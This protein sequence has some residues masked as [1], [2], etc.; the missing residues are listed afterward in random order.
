V[1]VLCLLFFTVAGVPYA[2]PR[3]GRVIDSATK[4][5]VSGV[6]VVA[7]FWRVGSQDTVW[8]CVRDTTDSSGA[9][10]LDVNEGSGAI[11]SYL[12]AGYGSL[13]LRYPKELNSKNEDYC[14]AEL[15]DVT[16]TRIEL[17]TLD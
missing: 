2:T 17:K 4:Q 15:I 9:Y 11:V 6:I 5:P 3:K 8:T 16:L 13:V 12:K 14:C 7:D 10:E 1:I